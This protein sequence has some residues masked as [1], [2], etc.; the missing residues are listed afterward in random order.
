MERPTPLSSL[1]I[2][3]ASVKPGQCPYEVATLH[4]NKV[5]S[6]MKSMRFK[7]MK[8]W[9][10]EK[11]EDVA[12]ERRAFLDT[13]RQ[14]FLL[15]KRLTSFKLQNMTDSVYNIEQK[16]GSTTAKMFRKERNEY[17]QVMKMH[18]DRFDFR[19]LQ[20]TFKDARTELMSLTYHELDRKMKKVKPDWS[21]Y[22]ELLDQTI[23]GRSTI[24]NKDN[25]I[26]ELNERIAELTAQNKVLEKA[27]AS[28]YTEGVSFTQ[29]P[30]EETKLKKRKGGD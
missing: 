28:A 21:G 8:A 1:E 15:N 10:K 18:E 9:K 11:M 19:Q 7:N 16:E 22:H 25:L 14:Q 23:T 4:H 17:N 6:E 2:N 12:C 20:I 24:M 3:H 5:E 30:E 13:Q 26:A 27:V 29:V